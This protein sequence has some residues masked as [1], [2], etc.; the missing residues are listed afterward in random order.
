MQEE[1]ERR[2]AEEDFRK[3]YRSWR[4]DV[5]RRHKPVDDYYARTYAEWRS[6]RRRSVVDDGVYWS[7]PFSVRLARRYAQRRWLLPLDMAIALGLFLL[8]LRMGAFHDFGKTPKS[9]DEAVDSPYTRALKKD[10]EKER[11]E[12]IQRNRQNGIY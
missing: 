3:T 4:A 8:L 9:M 5:Q 1:D 11:L 2:S 12:M 7:L 6:S 10:M